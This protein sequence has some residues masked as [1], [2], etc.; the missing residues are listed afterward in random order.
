MSNAGI[1]EAVWRAARLRDWHQ[2]R[3]CRSCKRPLHGTSAVCRSRKCPEYSHV[4]AGDQRQKLFRN[5]EAFAGNVLISA[6][7]APGSNEMA[8]DESVC[9]ALGKHQ[10]SG[11]LGC[12]VDDDTAAR[13]N[14]G[15]PDA[16]RRLHR[17]AYQETASRYGPGSVV[18]VARVWE[19]QARGLLHVHPV[20]GYETA[21]Q[22]AGARAYLARLGELAPKYGFGFVHSKRK[23]VKAMPAQ[24]AAAYLS[25]YFVKGRRGKVALWESVKSSA[26]PRSIIHVSTKLTM[27]TG[28]TMRTL[29]LKRALFFL[30][31]ESVSGDDLRVVAAL[32]KAFPGAEILAREHVDRGPPQ[33]SSRLASALD[34]SASARWDRLNRARG[35]TEPAS[36]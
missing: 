29:R 27:Q 34:A 9:C 18:L 32:L 28:C 24:N 6:V 30:W 7:T 19:L 2:V 33:P 4:W 16:W 26:M 22:M 36:G 15:A 17:R 35:R 8:W 23:L 10:H 12:R 20:L 5:L 13:W 31:G 1:S 3:R 25:S 14:R 11:W 21:A